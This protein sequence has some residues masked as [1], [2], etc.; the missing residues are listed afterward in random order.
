MIYEWKI[1]EVIEIWLKSVLIGS[2]EVHMCGFRSGDLW[3]SKYTLEDKRN[4]ESVPRTIGYKRSADS[5]VYLYDIF[6]D[7]INRVIMSVHDDAAYI[8][9]DVLDNSVGFA[10]ADLNRLTKMLEDPDT[11]IAIYYR[12][13]PKFEEPYSKYSS[14]CVE[15][16]ET[17]SGSKNIILRFRS[18]SKPL[19]S[20]DLYVGFEVAH[21]ANAPKVYVFKVKK[22]TVSLRNDRDNLAEYEAT[23]CGYHAPSE[24]AVEQAALYNNF[25][26]VVSDDIIKQAEKE[27]CYL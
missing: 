23:F 14:I 24:D 5:S 21:E 3:V 6:A 2:E 11:A 20:N 19:G 10:K 17:G 12:E 25:R 16:Y 13:H 18:G 8:V 26:W 4:K 27:A 1:K 22:K 9:G 15:E 7:D